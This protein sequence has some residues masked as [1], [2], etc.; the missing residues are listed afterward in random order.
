M[1]ISKRGI[2]ILL[3]VVMI[4]NTSL[5]VCAEEDTNSLLVEKNY[6][7]KEQ[8]LEYKEEIRISGEKD[9]SE[10]ELFAAYVDSVFYGTATSTYGTVAGRQ[11]TGD[12]KILYDA[13]VPV[14]H[15]IANGTRAASV[16]VIGQP[17]TDEEGHIYE[18]DAETTFLGNVLTEEMI[19]HVINA[20]LADLP[21]EMYWYD[22]VT[23]CIVTG[24]VGE[25]VVQVTMKFNVG[26]NYR[27]ADEYTIDTSKTSAAVNA[28][29]N[30]QEIVEKYAELSDYEKLVGYKKEICEL[31]S[32][33][34]EAADGNVFVENIDPWQIIYVCP[35]LNSRS[36]P[37]LSPHLAP[38]S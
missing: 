2:S 11:L 7:T 12:E 3:A 14:I 25:A 23:G 34:Q 31:V 33:D 5:H 17:F 19:E 32:Y 1:S 20:L 10:E 13:L 4:L 15:Q 22:K 24:I 26:D 30:A 37:G 29:A 21:Y 18:V 38:A 27:G 35:R 36:H 28:V 9:V 16:I 8:M 6:V